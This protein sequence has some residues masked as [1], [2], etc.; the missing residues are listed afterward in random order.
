MR[1]TSGMKRGVRAGR[2]RGTANKHSTAFKAALWKTFQALGGVPTLAKWGREHPTEFYA[3]CGQLL[4]QHPF[5][6][7]IDVLLKQLERT[8]ARGEDL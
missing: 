5:P 8:P 2:R 7:G 1:N 4:L 6:S 3:L